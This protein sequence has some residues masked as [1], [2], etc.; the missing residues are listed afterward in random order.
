MTSKSD[1]NTAR[2]EKCAQKREHFQDLVRQLPFSCLAV[3]NDAIRFI[4]YWTIIA[5]NILFIDQRLTT[6][7]NKATIRF[8]E[9]TGVFYSGDICLRF[10]GIASSSDNI[11]RHAATSN[12]PSVR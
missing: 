11:S 4:S 8:L 7:Q 2:D 1:R 3:D 6:D 10:R 12:T 5:A 9:S